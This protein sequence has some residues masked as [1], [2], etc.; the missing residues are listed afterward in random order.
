[1]AKKKRVPKR[2]N[3]LTSV[4]NIVLLIIVV[5][6]VSSLVTLLI[7]NHTHK[8]T[9]EVKRLAYDFTVTDGVSMLLDTDILHFGGGPAGARLQR[10]LNI[11]TS[12]DAKVK[13]SWIGDGN[14]VVSEN[15][16]LIHANESKN[17]LFYL[18][19]PSNASQGSYTGELIFEFYR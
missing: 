15:N 5:V 19:I 6:L 9:F 11:T 3:D 8:K 1:M 10:G 16:F 2:K 12:K 14:I 4:T 7:V 17:L 18:D 13:I